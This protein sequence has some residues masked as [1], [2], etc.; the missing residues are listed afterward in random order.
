MRNLLSS[1][2]LPC[3]A[4]CWWMWEDVLTQALYR[5]SVPSPHLQ[6]CHIT[7]PGHFPC[8]PCPRLSTAKLLLTFSAQCC[9]WCKAAFIRAVFTKGLILSTPSHSILINK[10]PCAVCSCVPEVVAE[11][12]QIKVQ[13]PEIT[14]K[15]CLLM[16]PFCQNKSC[17]IIWKS[18]SPGAMDLQKGRLP[19]RLFLLW[20][21][22]SHS[23]LLYLTTWALSILNA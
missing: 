4:S 12:L 21:I 5:L 1:L 14:P 11:A 19:G 2:P 18:L 15:R 13:L 3:S 20:G 8:S 9:S 23:G 10:N 22:C 16:Y 17:S 6:L 7:W